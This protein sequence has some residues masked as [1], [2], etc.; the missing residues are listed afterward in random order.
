MGLNTVPE[1]WY[2][3]Y[4]GF[5]RWRNRI[6]QMAGYELYVFSDPTIS[7]EFPTIP[8]EHEDNIPAG[9]TYGDWGDVEPP[10]ALYYLFFHSDCE[11]ILTPKACLGIFQRL[12]EVTKPILATGDEKFLDRTKTFMVGLLIC[13]NENRPMEFH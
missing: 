1:A 3:S 5:N 9:C 13:I 4:S 6:A 7:F 12:V 10:D 11:G 8:K 2:G